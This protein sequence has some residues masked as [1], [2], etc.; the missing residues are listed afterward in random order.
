MAWAVNPQV[1]A[2]LG[3]A[4]TLAAVLL[5]IAPMSTFRR[6]IASESTEEFSPFPYVSTLLNCSVWVLYALP[7]IT[8]NRTAPL[9][10]NAIGIIFQ[11][12]Y[13]FLFVYYAR[14]KP[15]KY[16]LSLLG[17]FVLFMSALLLL[18]LG[19]LSEESRSPTVG[20]FAMFFTVVMFGAPLSSLAVVIRTL[21]VEFMPLPL[22]L[23]GFAC[24]TVWTLYGIYVQDQYVIVP[25][26]FG[27]ALGLV[28]LVIYFYVSRKA[29]QKKKFS[30]AEEDGSGEGL[31]QRDV[32]MTS[33]PKSAAN[34]ASGFLDAHKRVRP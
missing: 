33:G 20:Y 6:I 18:V 8:P 15:K 2:S 17:G 16:V 26:L 27:M 14:D 32:L 11:S 21:S 4:G 25:N 24:S 34:E 13:I 23:M 28:Q 3:L 9:V 7:Y 31:I 12:V 30:V 19:Y 5:F 29:A 1:E 22:S 10:T